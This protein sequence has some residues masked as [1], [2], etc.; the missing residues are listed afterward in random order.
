MKLAERGISQVV[1]GFLP[2]Q[3][4]DL[5][6]RVWRVTRWLNPNYVALDQE[7]VRDEILSAIHPWDGIDNGLAGRLRAG[8]EVHIVTPSRSGVEV[9]PFPRLFKCKL[10]GRLEKKVDHQCKCGEKAWVAFPFVTYHSCGMIEVPFIDVCATHKQVRVNNPKSNNSRDLKF[11]CPICN[12]KVQDGFRFLNC[13]C[14]R[15]RVDYNVH[16]A[17]VVFNPHATVIVNPPNEAVARQ[18]RTPSARTDT[19]Q[20]VLNSMSQS[21]PLD[22]TL[23]LDT[24]IEM[25]MAKGATEQMARS[26]AQA[27]AAQSGGILSAAKSD[28]ALSMDA[29]ERGSDAALKLAYA[30]SG[31]RT[32]LEDLRTHATPA[33]KERYEDDYPAAIREC[34]LERVEF[35]R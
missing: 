34:G 2:S 1:F 8:M 31:G 6:N 27:A 3:T 24:L 30:T 20:W 10:C 28:I 18:L 14:G 33:M 12:N 13:E 11:T 23:S 25:F 4:V 17:G 32:T 19:L 5:S 15:G 26:M 16:R 22:E 21:K 9:E 29:K 7:I 35:L